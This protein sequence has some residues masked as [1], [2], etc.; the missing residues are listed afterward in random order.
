LPPNSGRG[1][2]AL[3]HNATC[4]QRARRARLASKHAEILAAVTAVEA[5]VSELKRMVLTNDV[6]PA[7]ASR[8]LEQATTE[9]TNQ[10]RATTPDTQDHQPHRSR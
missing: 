1:R 3:F 8:A 7:D 2:P 4:R 10:L 6:P 5:A 9:L